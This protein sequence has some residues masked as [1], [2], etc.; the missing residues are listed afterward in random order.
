MQVVFG[1]LYRDTS[2]CFFPLARLLSRDHTYTSPIEMCVR[3]FFE[4]CV[5]VILL[6]VTLSNF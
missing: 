1:F 2:L 6:Y 4:G 3:D 5:Y